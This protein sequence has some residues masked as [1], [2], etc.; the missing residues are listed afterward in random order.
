MPRGQSPGRRNIVWS[1]ADLDNI[2]WGDVDLD[3]IVWSDADLDNIVWSDM[4]VALLG[5]HQVMEKMPYRASLD[6]PSCGARTPH[7]GAVTS[8][9]LAQRPAG[10]VTAAR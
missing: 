10:A 4:I 1:D 3:N 5:R 7:L 6:R 2:V 8:S 9:Q